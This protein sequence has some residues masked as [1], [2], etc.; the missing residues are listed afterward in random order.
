MYSFLN[1]FGYVQSVHKIVLQ[2]CEL[3]S[4]T[5]I[6][7]LIQHS[8]QS[9]CSFSM[10]AAFNWL[11]I[12]TWRTRKT[13]L[14]YSQLLSALREER[15]L[16]KYSLVI[17][18]HLHSAVFCVGDGA[19]KL[20]G[21]LWRGTLTWSLWIAWWEGFGSEPSAIWYGFAPIKEIL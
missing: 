16:E 6:K 13:D 4:P 17:K 2:S 8:M 10:T 21:V 15:S 7:I 18:N 3:I 1:T 5:W 20:V 12:Q 14:I 11:C 19:E 9:W